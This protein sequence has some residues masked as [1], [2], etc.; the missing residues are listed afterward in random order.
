MSVLPVKEFTRGK[1]AGDGWSVGKGETGKL[2][3]VDSETGKGE[4]TG[5]ETGGESAPI[6]FGASVLDVEGTEMGE[7]T[8]TGVSFCVVTGGAVRDNWLPLRHGSIA[9][10][11][12][13]VTIIASA[14]IT[15]TGIV[16]RR[17][18]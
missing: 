11:I 12:T 10:I 16:G 13:A 4:E 3:A 6:V 15:Q 14:A 5:N 18:C 8:I 1:A 17:I 2:A 9:I 7:A